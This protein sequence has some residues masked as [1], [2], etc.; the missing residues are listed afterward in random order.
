[1]VVVKSCWFPRELCDICSLHGM[2]SFFRKERLHLHF[3]SN[4]CYISVHDRPSSQMNKLETTRLETPCAYSPNM[5]YLAQFLGHTCFLNHAFHT[6]R[7]CQLMSF[8]FLPHFHFL[9]TLHLSSW[10][11]TLC[12]MGYFRSRAISFRAMILASTM[13]SA[14]V[15]NMKKAPTNARPNDHDR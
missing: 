4:E 7:S 6:L 8:L 12:S 13:N 10:G 9:V 1:M 3:S 15:R 11:Y 14:P 2:S 5:I